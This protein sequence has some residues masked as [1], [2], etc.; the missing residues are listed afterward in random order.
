MDDLNNAIRLATL[1]SPSDAVS[2]SQAKLLAQAH[3]QQATWLYA[4]SK[5]TK[6]REASSNS[7]EQAIKSSSWLSSKQPIGHVIRRS[8]HP[9]PLSMPHFFSSDNNRTSPRRWPPRTTSPLLSGGCQRLAVVA[10]PGA[11]QPFCFTLSMRPLIFAA[12]FLRELRTCQSLR[13]V[14]KLLDR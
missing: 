12:S 5:H 9:V 11:S 13:V 4:K 10:F 3:T 1:A 2:P 8:A 7:K 6:G 14:A